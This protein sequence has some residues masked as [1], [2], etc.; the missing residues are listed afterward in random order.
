MDEANEE[1]NCCSIGRKVF[2]NLI[3]VRLIE[4]RM[5]SSIP[6][7][8]VGP[9]EQTKGHLLIFVLSMIQLET[10]K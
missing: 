10:T 4:E 1:Y 6:M 7:R 9:G 8:M 5:W 3:V 2:L